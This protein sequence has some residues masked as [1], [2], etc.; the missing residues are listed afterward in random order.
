MLDANHAFQ[1]DREFVEGRSLAGLDPSL[2]TAHVGDAGRGGLRIYATDIFVDQL[3]L[4]SGGLNASGLGDECG[5]SKTD[6]NIM[7]G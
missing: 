7:S 5:H 2:R 1:D 6:Y 4:V 3:G